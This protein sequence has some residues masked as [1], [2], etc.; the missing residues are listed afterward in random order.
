MRHWFDPRQGGN[1]RTVDGI[2][3]GE[4]Y[5]YMKTSGDRRADHFTPLILTEWSFIFILDL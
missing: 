5:R 4:V 2:Q 3:H 1:F